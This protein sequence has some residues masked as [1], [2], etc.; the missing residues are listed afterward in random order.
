MKTQKTTTSPLYTTKPYCV[1]EH[2]KLQ[3]VLYQRTSNR[4]H[5]ATCYCTYH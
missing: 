1:Y 5:W 4:S 3:T 2:F